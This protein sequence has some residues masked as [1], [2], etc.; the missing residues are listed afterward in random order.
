MQADP[1]PGQRQFNAETADTL[2]APAIQP[3][4][5]AAEENL[6]HPPD[7]GQLTPVVAC[8]FYLVR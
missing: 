8:N 5:I 2:N 1:F 4:G 7:Y 6:K 3:W